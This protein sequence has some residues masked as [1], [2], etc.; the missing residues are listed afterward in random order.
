MAVFE[1]LEGAR[2]TLVSAPAGSG[3]T[4]AVDSWLRGRRDLSV[5]W[6][7]IERGETAARELW[8][9]VAM[10][11]DRLRPGIAR[12]ALAKLRAPDST[13]AEA[14]DGLLRDLAGYAGQIVIVLDDL[15][16]MTDKDGLKLLEYA[17]QRLPTSTR[18]IATTRA[19]PS[20]RL[21]AFRGRGVLGEVRA[22]EL[23]FTVEE[24]EAFLDSRGITGL[25]HED[26]EAVGGTHGRLAGGHSTRGHVA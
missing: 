9:S 20:I 8:T 3:K 16:H 26:V 6:V 5:A 4:V 2:L 11:V 23:A 15:H 7:S 21:T 17:V 24:A 1:R 18:V 12:P 14:I 25:D 22:R 13:V 10:G 19:D